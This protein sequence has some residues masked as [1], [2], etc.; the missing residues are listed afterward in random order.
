MLKTDADGRAVWRWDGV[1]QAMVVGA[2]VEAPAGSG[3]H[4][5]VVEKVAAEGAVVAVWRLGSRPVLAGAG[6]AVHVSASCILTT[7]DSAATP[8]P[9]P[10]RDNGIDR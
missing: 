1:R 5:A 6:V 4:L 3:P 2:V 8:G 7:S 10:L 9:K